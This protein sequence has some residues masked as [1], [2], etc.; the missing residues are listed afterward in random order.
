MTK[1]DVDLLK[2]K[3]NVPNL[4]E[5]SPLVY[6][7]ANFTYGKETYQGMIAGGAENLSTLFDV[8]PNPTTGILNFS[9]NIKSINIYDVSGRFIKK[10][11]NI[12]NQVDISQFSQGMYLIES[13]TFDNQKHTKKVIKE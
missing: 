4:E 2:I 7:G 5:I 11:E 12:S 10:F 8:Y 13:H 9:E 3:S 1:Q 6:T